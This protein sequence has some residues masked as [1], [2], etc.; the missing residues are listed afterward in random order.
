MEI[1]NVASKMTLGQVRDE[2]EVFNRNGTSRLGVMHLRNW[3]DAIDERLKAEDGMVLVPER[4][5]K[6][7]SNYVRC[8][9]SGTNLSPYIKENGLH[10]GSPWAE[11]VGEHAAMLTAAP[12]PKVQPPKDARC[13]ARV[14]HPKVA[15]PGPGNPPL[16]C[17]LKEGHDGPHRHNGGGAYPSIPFRDTD[18]VSMEPLSTQPKVQP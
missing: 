10:G 1:K 6:A 17:F 4:F 16:W 9:T 14:V 2:M 8:A 7:A 18:E 5:V 3:L 11:F 12:Q 13:P 15:A